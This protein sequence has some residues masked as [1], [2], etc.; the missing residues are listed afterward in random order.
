MQ[1]KKASRGVGD[2]IA[3]LTKFFGIQPCGG[4]ERRQDK[5]NRWLPYQNTPNVET[6]QA[7]SGHKISDNIAVGD[8]AGVVQSAQASSVNQV[9][10]IPANF[11]RAS[12]IRSVGRV[13]VANRSPQSSLIF[14]GVDIIRE[15][16]SSAAL[17]RDIYQGRNREEFLAIF[18]STGGWRA[19]DRRRGPADLEGDRRVRRSERR[20]REDTRRDSWRSRSSS[21]TP[22]PPG[23][24]AP[25]SFA[26]GVDVTDKTKGAIRATKAMFAR[27]NDSDKHEACESL[28][29]FST[30]AIAWDILELHQQVTSDTINS[31]FRPACATSG[32]SPACGSSVTVDGSCHFAGSANYV[33]F[34]VMCRLCTDHYRRMINSASWYEI[35][36]KDSYLQGIRSLN[37]NGMLG[38]IDLYK[39]YVP[40]LRLESPAGNIDAAKRWSMAGYDGWPNGVATPA[41]DR[42]NCTLTCPVITSIPQF[43]VSWYP[44]SNAYSRR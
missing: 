9:D 17:R 33:I 6:I 23:G 22:T 34:G 39:K 18:A 4:C 14:P 26:C 35:F 43:R 20:D 11:S 8:M 36:D 16:E 21:V 10:S 15:I 12:Q 1:A 41:G 2:T 24:A 37:R 42:T 29:S 5:L 7:A 13:S 40:L 27:W 28:Y 44:H 38:L 3:K 32:A 19:P 25:A 30:G 31:G